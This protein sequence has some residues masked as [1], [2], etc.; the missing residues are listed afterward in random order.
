MARDREIKYY[1]WPQGEGKLPPTYFKT[2][3][4]EKG[5]YHTDKAV[6][7]ISVI[8]IM[9]GNLRPPY[10]T[11]GCEELAAILLGNA[12]EITQEEFLQARIERIR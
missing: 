8:D 11:Y 1:K 6:V 5:T 9:E 7:D 4:R 2:D 3:V 10:T 12:I